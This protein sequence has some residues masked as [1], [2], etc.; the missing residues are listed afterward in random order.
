MRSNIISCKYTF[1][2]PYWDSVSTV[3]KSFITSLLVY[4]PHQRMT[5]TEAIN[6]TWLLTDSNQLIHN[7]LV[8]NLQILAKYQ[9]LKKLRAVTTAI[10]AINRMK[11]RTY[12]SD[13]D[14]SRHSTSSLNN[15]RH[16]TSLDNSR[17]NTSLDNSRHNTS[18]DNSRHS[19]NSQSQIRLSVSIDDDLTLQRLKT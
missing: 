19:I 10:I 11:L 6:H 15:S 3:A 8:K 9:K 5:A 12:S 13:L 2:A 18:L 17:H 1:Q 16:N 7:N 4:D 14:D